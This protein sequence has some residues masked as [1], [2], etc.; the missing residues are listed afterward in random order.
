MSHPLMA[1]TLGRSQPGVEQEKNLEVI[2]MYE[3]GEL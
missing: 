1:L 2:V 3:E